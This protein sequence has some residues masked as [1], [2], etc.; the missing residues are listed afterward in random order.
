[1]LTYWADSGR[2]TAASL[3]CGRFAATQTID[4]GEPS[5]TSNANAAICADLRHC[6]P[7]FADKKYR[8]ERFGLA[9]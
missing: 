2:R 5:R 9:F 1:M 4:G 7:A 6:S 3:R 8:G